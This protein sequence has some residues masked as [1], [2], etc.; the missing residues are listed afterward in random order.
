MGRQR[1]WE[2][3]DVSQKQTMPS[4]IFRR[5]SD[6]PRASQNLSAPPGLFPRLSDSSGAS[7]NFPMPLRLF[8]RLSELS[9]ASQNFSVAHRF[10]RWSPEKFWEPPEKSEDRRKNLRAIGKF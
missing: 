9:V 10:F 4:R 2:R 3:E 6:L 7:Q 5:L 8:R 1:G